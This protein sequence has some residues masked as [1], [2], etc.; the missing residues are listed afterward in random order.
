MS[1]RVIDGLGDSGSAPLTLTGKAYI[2]P[3]GLIR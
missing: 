1:I 2:T 3:V